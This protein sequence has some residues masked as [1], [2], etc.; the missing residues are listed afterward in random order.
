MAHPWKGDAMAADPATG[1]RPSSSHQVLRVAVL[2]YGLGGSAF[3]AP[4]ITAV[5]GLTVAAVVTGDPERSAAVGARYPAARVVPDADGI[6]AMAPELDVAVITTPNRTHVPLALAALDAGLHVVVD[7]PLAATAGEGLRV[8]DAA[9]SRGRVLTVYQ[10]RRWDGDF[11]TLRRLLDEGTLG[12]VYR[13]ESRF[14]RWRPEPKPGWKQSPAPEDAGGI[15]FDLGTHLID[16]A[17]VLFG[18]VRDVH[19]EL[20][21]RRPGAEVED[22]VF[23]ALTHENGVRSHLWMSAV[24][25]DSGPRFRVLGSRGAWV[26]EGLDVQEDRLRAGR[27]PAEPG[28][29]DE[30][31][32]R[33]GVLHDGAAARPIRTEPGAYTEFY[34]GLRRAVADG[35]P[36]PVEPADAVAGLEIVERARGR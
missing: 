6:W 17:R 30:P 2:G 9:R 25:A 29:G 31:P 26:K 36:P 18:P 28:F 33:W 3:H 34:E 13:F 1:D 27:D 24:A 12:D 8:I 16:Q 11:L 19:A 23:L 10:N 22:D 4:V 5:P 15:L 21:A 35:G 7:K 20:D 14:E 32:E